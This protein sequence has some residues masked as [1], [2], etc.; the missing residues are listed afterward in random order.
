MKLNAYVYPAQKL[1]LAKQRS[2]AHLCQPFTDRDERSATGKELP[3]R[4]AGSATPFIRA[5]CRIHAG[6]VLSLY[7]IHVGC[8]RRIAGGLHQGV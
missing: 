3:E 7:Q 1:A 2:I 5:A 6:C 4:K 8:R